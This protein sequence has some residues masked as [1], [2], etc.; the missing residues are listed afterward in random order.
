[1]FILGIFYFFAGIIQQTMKKLNFKFLLLFILSTFIVGCRSESFITED[2]HEISIPRTGEYTLK[3]APIFKQFLLNNVINK[4]SINKNNVVLNDNQSIFIVYKE[5]ST[6]YSTIIKNIDGNSFDVWVYT[7]GKDKETF[8]LAEYTPK[9]PKMNSD[10]NHFTGIVNYKSI[11]GSLLGTIKFINGEPKNKSTI[12]PSSENGKVRTCSLLVISTPVSCASPEHH[13]PWETCYETGSDRPYYDTEIHKI[14]TE[15]QFP[16]IGLDGGG[17]YGGGGGNSSGGEPSAEVSIQDAFNMQLIQSNYPELTPEQYS[18]IENNQYIGGQ[19]LGYFGWNLT[20]NYH[21]L[22]LWC[23][24]YLRV[25]N[26]FNLSEYKAFKKIEDFINF[27]QQFFTNNPSTTWQQFEKWFVNSDGTINL[28]LNS[29]TV[30]INNSININSLQNLNNQLINK[31]NVTF[32]DA[33][34]QDNGSEK[35][36]S[37]RV[38]RTGIWG[39]GEEVRIKLK[40]NNNLWAFDSVT[41]SELGLTLGTWTFTQI[42]YTQ[43]T[44]GNVLTVEVTGYENYNLFLEGIGTIYKDKVMIRVK[45]NATTGNIFSIEFVDL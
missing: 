9:N 22:A 25:N 5:K 16:N 29:T 33:V 38:K 31:N 10:L 41:S 21:Q 4:T 14:C 20:D 42:D 27:G 23:I 44:S 45:I 30:N 12:T 32:E 28:E 43:N 36:V 1:M 15:S 35:V 34:L 26:N 40:K 3:E 17:G 24:D 13:M 7:V 39:S 11:D 18:Y 37:A 19:I 6:S 8:F 2:S